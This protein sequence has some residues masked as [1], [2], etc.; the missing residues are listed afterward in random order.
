MK[1]P[2]NYLK[3]AFVRMYIG[4]TCGVLAVFT[5]SIS[6]A[7]ASE[8][9]PVKLR[10]DW[11]TL[12]YH[13]P[14]Y[15]GVA[16]GIYEQ[17]GIKLTI[18]EGKGSASVA[19]LAASGNDD[20]GF[21][22]ATTVAQLVAK[23]LP[24]KVVMGILRGT[25]LA[26]FFPSDRGIKAPADLQGR[27][28]SVCPGDAISVYIEPYLKSLGLTGT[29]L[30]KL[31]VDCTLKYTV[32]A[33]GRADLV[34]SYGTAGK[35]LLQKVGI[36]EPATIP[37]GPGFYLPGHGIVASNK[38]INERPDVIRR[39]VAAT[40]KA[41]DAAAK[42]PDGAVKAVT[43]AR[44]LLKSDQAALKDT[45]LISLNYLDAPSSSGHPFGWQSPQDWETALDLLDQ[46]A[47]MASSIEPSDVMTNDF[48]QGK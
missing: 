5:T 38:L 45:L 35:P 47:D 19:Q 20:F 32:V 4:F 34:M 1:K 30:S 16:Q 43:D 14:F 12:G 25:T 13:A 15:Y 37:P 23:G 29:E 27:K 41:W 46:Y 42:D 26:M 6:P 9:V 24:G 17:E 28:I 22:D 10:L 2:L 11:T 8:T 3:H 33:Q 31:S 7:M 40:A 39:F 48:I 44:P 36:S 18:E 21:S